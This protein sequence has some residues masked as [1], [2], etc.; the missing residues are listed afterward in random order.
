MF[1]GCRPTHING[2]AVSDCKL[3][4]VSQKVA[5]GGKSIKVSP[6]HKPGPIMA[7]H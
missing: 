4:T 5:R 3:V 1:F 6:R 2:L 7:H